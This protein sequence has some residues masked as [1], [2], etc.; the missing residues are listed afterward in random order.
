MDLIPFS[1]S[2]L[3]SENTEET[4]GPDCHLPDLP[5]QT[6][7]VAPAPI[8]HLEQTGWHGQ[9][10]GAAIFESHDPRFCDRKE[11]TNQATTE[12]PTPAGSPRGAGQMGPQRDTPSQLSGAAQLWVEGSGQPRPV[13]SPPC[14]GRGV[15]RAVHWATR[16]QS[17][18]RAHIPAPA[19][20]HTHISVMVSGRLAGMAVRPLPRQSTMPLPQVHMAGQ[21]PEERVQESDRPASPW[22]EKTVGGDLGASHARAS[23]PRHGV[24][25]GDRADSVSLHPDKPEEITEN[26][27]ATLRAPRTQHVLAECLPSLNLNL[28]VLPESVVHT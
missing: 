9:R 22:P 21:E 6:R 23:T 25:G 7:P 3:Q 18:P 26:D 1:S 4:R 2:R 13:V 8:L 12:K 10:K 19:L 11:P 27:H 28:T 16:A 24:M 5:A 15:R 17:G 20:A 14:I